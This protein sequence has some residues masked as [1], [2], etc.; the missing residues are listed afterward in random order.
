ME[1]LR[2]NEDKYI[3]MLDFLHRWRTELIG[4]LLPFMNTYIK[5]GNCTVKTR[6]QTTENLRM[7]NLA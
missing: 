1:K 5:D 7:D 3:L 2:R 6:E 4:P